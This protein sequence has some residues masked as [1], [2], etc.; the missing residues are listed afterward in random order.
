MAHKYVCKIEF[1]FKFH[2]LNVWMINGLCKS[3]L[4]TVC[5]WSLCVTGAT[6]HW[7]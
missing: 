1:A 4:V 5:D 6:D 7:M 3:L 2:V